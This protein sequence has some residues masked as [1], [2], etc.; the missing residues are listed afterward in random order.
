MRMHGRVLHFTFVFFLF[1]EC[2]QW[3]LLME[4]DQYNHTL[5]MFVSEPYLKRNVQNLGLPSPEN[6]RPEKLPVLGGL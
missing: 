5:Y 3:T 1:L 4:L 6:A 2:H